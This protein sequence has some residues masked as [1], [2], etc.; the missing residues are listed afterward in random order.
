M[1]A[2][3]DPQLSFESH[4][5]HIDKT[6]YYNLGSITRLRRLLSQQ[7]TELLIHAFI[8]TRLNYYNLFLASLP[9]CTL[10]SL[11]F[12]ENSAAGVSSN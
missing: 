6:S 3:F 4:I 7:D 11:D 2:I 8:T 5:G 10:L 1:S 12:G 9:E